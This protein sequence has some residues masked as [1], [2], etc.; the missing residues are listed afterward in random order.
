[1]TAMDDGTTWGTCEIAMPPWMHDAYPDQRPLGATTKSWQGCDLGKAR[2]SRNMVVLTNGAVTAGFEDLGAE[3]Q[4]RLEADGWFPMDRADETDLVEI[5]ERM[6]EY[7]VFRARLREGA[8]I[9][10]ELLRR[11]AAEIRRL[12]RH[13]PS[14]AIDQEP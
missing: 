7:G 6:A 9:S 12:R 11:A 14:R 3:E 10:P 13:V 4:E 2:P 5:L 8:S 1:M